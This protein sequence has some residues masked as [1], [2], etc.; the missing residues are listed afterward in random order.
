MG[1]R[2][3]HGGDVPREGVT[4]GILHCAQ[5]DGLALEDGW[6]ARRWGKSAPL[7]SKGCGARRWWGLTVVEVGG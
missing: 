7:K 5:G 4:R 1:R 3:V 6:E 2:G